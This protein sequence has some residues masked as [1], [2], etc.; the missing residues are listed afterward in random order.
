MVVIESGNPSPKMP[1]VTGLGMNVICPEYGNFGGIFRFIF[2]NS[3]S[4]L[5]LIITKS[6]VHSIL[7]LR[8]WGYMLLLLFMAEIRRSP[9]EVGS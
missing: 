6:L 5:S 4:K 7:H 8:F 3:A 9:V 1:L 2:S